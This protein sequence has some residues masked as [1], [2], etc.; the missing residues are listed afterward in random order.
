LVNRFVSSPSF[1]RGTNPHTWMLSS[2]NIYD[3]KLD[4]RKN[5]MFD[6]FPLYHFFPISE[7]KFYNPREYKFSS[8][9]S[10]FWKWKRSPITSQYFESITELKNR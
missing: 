9:L 5:M 10:L 7:D 3:Y 4:K 2:Q 8:F 1:S 6:V